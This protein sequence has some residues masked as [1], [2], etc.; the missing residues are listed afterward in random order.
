[1][2]FFYSTFD[3]QGNF[4]FRRPE[5]SSES[6]SHIPVYL[7]L[8]S[9]KVET[10]DIRSGFQVT[11]GSGNIYRFKEAEYSNTGKI[12]GWKLTDVTSLKQD[13]LSFSYV[14]QKLTYADSYD[15]YAVE[16]M[17]ESYRNGYWQ[18]VDG[19]LKFFRMNGYA[20]HND[21]LWADFTAENV[22]QYDNRPYNSVDAKYP[23]E[24][25]YANGKVVFDYS[26]SLLKNRAYL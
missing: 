1:M 19:K 2:C 12:T 9:D 18:G 21:S 7:P 23:K 22:G 4:V 6:G 5:K 24:I 25:T 20:L 15:Y 14:T 11:D 26:S 8:T 13:R 17:G 10:S 16:D 3:A